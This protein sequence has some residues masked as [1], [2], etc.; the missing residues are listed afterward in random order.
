MKIR[1]RDW[2]LMTGSEDRKHRVVEVVETF[3][4]TKSVRVAKLNGERLTVSPDQIES[5]VEANEVS[6]YRQG[7]PVGFCRICGVVLWG[8]DRVKAGISGRCADLAKQ[9]MTDDQIRE[10]RKVSKPLEKLTR[11]IADIVAVS[12]PAKIEIR[13]EPCDRSAE[14]VE[15]Y[16]KVRQTVQMRPIPKERP[17]I[18]VWHG[19]LLPPAWQARVDRMV[20]ESGGDAFPLV[21]REPT[22]EELRRIE[23]TEEKPA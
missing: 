2:Y 11:V 17:S 20:A 19:S 16:A 14:K 8:E 4:D 3:G 21:V 22:D 12:E 13:E 15:A 9:G 1:I 18:E 5:K 10:A 7:L 23:G 6:A